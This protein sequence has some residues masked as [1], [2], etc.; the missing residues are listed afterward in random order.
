MKQIEY[1]LKRRT[2]G[3][4][5]WDV[6]VDGKTAFRIRFELFSLLDPTY[7]VMLVPHNIRLLSPS[8]ILSLRKRFN[9]IGAKLICQCA[10]DSQIDIRFAKLFG[11]IVQTTIGDRLHMEREP[12]N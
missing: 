6:I 10:L 1:K 3:L 4:E 7:Y 9:K 8:V 2:D 11:F 12:C 5:L